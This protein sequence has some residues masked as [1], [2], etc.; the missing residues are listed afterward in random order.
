[1]KKCLII[2]L[3]LL[4]ACSGL[5]KGGSIASTDQRNRYLKFKQFQSDTLGYVQHNFIVNKKKYIGK[6]LNT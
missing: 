3:I 1:M 6:E 4:S 2:L 5:R